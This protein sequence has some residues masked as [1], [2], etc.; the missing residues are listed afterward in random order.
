VTRDRRR[1]HRTAATAAF[2][3]A[4]LG[5]TGCAHGSTPR[6]A[7]ARPAREW[8]TTVPLHGKPLEIH[9]AAPGSPAIDQVVVLYASGDGGWLGAA[10]D[11]FHQIAKAGYYT[12]GFSSRAFLKIERSGATLTTTAQLAA[13]YAQILS[14]GRTN[15]GLDPA[16]R[17]ILTGWSRGAAFAVLAASEPAARR[18][19][20]GVVAIGLSD[21][22]DLAIDGPEDESDDG[23]A[24]SAAN[25]G[26]FDT[27]TSLAHLA[28]LPCAVIQASRDDY[29]PAARARVLFGADTPSRRFYTVAARNHRFSG[30]KP[31]FNAALLDAIQWM[32]SQAVRDPAH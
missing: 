9:L 32:I 29:L 31:A 27:Y 16:G 17:A 15:L 5:L 25:R 23:S 28:P 18:G 19:I 24:S 30:G 7:P 14:R 26:A 10:V 11:M 20:L 8:S 4:V 13:E 3:A 21:R 1:V 22:E 12:I 6:A 2:A